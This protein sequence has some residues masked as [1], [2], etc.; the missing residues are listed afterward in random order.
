LGT[1]SS[2]PTSNTSGAYSPSGPNSSC[3]LVGARVVTPDAPGAIQREAIAGLRF[4]EHQLAGAI[5]RQLRERTR[6]ARA[7]AG[8]EHA[9][10]KQVRAIKRAQERRVRV[11]QGAAKR[12]FGPRDVG[13]RRRRHHADEARGQPRDGRAEA[14]EERRAPGGPRSAPSQRRIA[15]CSSICC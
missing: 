13:R 8:D 15:R 4:G 9:L 11:G 1:I 5:L 6:R 2:P 7:D 10:V 14:I 12:R 3:A